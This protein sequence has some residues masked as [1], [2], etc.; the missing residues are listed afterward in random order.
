MTDQQTD[1]LIIGIAATR[2]AGGGGPDRAAIALDKGTEQPIRMDDILYAFTQGGVA[3]DSPL[4]LAPWGT[5]TSFSPATVYIRTDDALYRVG[6]E[7]LRA[8]KELLPDSFQQVSRSVVANLV[9]T[10]LLELQG[11]ANR[12]HTLTYTVVRNEL[13][14]GLERI[15]IGREFLFGVR[16]RFGYRRGVFERTFESGVLPPEPTAHPVEAARSSE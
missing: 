13:S 3:G 12:V 1:Q 9:R 5:K 7:S 11:S 14:W 2:I 6:H 15:K 4:I 8:F 16:E 10:H